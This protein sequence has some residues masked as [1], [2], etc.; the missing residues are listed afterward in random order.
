MF[1]FL[2]T[3]VVPSTVC[4]SV[5]EQCICYRLRAEEM[6]L[7]WVAYSSTRNGLKLKMHNLEQFEHDVTTVAFITSSRFSCFDTNYSMSIIFPGVKKEES[8]QKK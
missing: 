6:I 4:P 3:D 5:V 8:I 1:P 2:L 7:E